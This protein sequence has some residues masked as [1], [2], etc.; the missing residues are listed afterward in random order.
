M[1]PAVRRSAI[2]FPF[3]SPP[4][5][6]VV[7]AFLVVAAAARGATPAPASWSLHEGDR[8]VFLGDALVEREG[9]RGAIETALVATHPD[10]DLTFR[11]LGWSGD[12]VW[13]ESRGVFDQPSAGYAR[14]LPLVDSLEPAVVVI[15]YGRNESFA[16][17]AGLAPFR[18]QLA[19]LCRDLRAPRQ[20]RG[21][22]PLRLV[23]VTPPPFEATP[24]LSAATAAARNAALSRYAA[25]IRDVA[26]EV[27]AGIVDLFDGVVAR[28]PAGERLTENG[29][30]LTDA[31]YEAAA[32]VFAAACGRPLSGDHAGRTAALRD[33]VNEKNR[34]FFHRW[35]PANETYLFLFRRHEQGNNAV[36]I[37][38]FDPLVEAAEAK[39][40]D[41][42]RETR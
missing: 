36:E 8:V 4:C 39:V 34:L 35:R 17:A 6:G 42:A 1:L 27:E 25:A 18:D 13:A 37:L 29:V 10:A 24:P 2:G 7:L 22:D 31:G 15:A 11:N 21:H 5:L 26:L 30:H 16:G 20:E 40:R 14:L 12:T 9:E 33:A 23:L 19:R 28:L 38:Q 41:L 32:A 3:T